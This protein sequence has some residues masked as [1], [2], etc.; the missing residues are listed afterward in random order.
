M[1]SPASRPPSSLYPRSPLSPLRALRA[2]LPS[3]ATVVVRHHLSFA[4][5]LISERSCRRWSRNFR[6]SFLETP[7]LPLS[8]SSSPLQPTFH[9]FLLSLSYLIFI[10]HSGRGSKKGRPTVEVRRRVEEASGRVREQGRHELHVCAAFL[11]LSSRD[12]HDLGRST[13]ARL[14]KG[15][16]GWNRLSKSRWCSK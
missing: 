7:S 12:F 15:D 4:S 2:S 9:F 3:S 5:L 11:C 10:P 1:T 6:E 13:S 8:P 14:E 16:G